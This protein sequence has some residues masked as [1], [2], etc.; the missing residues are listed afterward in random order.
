MY[1]TVAEMQSE[2]VSWVLGQL[3]GKKLG[4]R[5]WLICSEFIF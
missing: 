1:K 2:V 5:G 3:C 4:K